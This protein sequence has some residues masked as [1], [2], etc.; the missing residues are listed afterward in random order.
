MRSIKEIHCVPTVFFPVTMEFAAINLV[1]V[2]EVPHL[3]SDLLI[4]RIVLRTTEVQSNAVMGPSYQMQEIVRAHWIPGAF[5]HLEIAIGSATWTA[6]QT[7]KEG[8]EPPMWQRHR[9]TGRI[10]DMTRDETALAHQSRHPNV[11][12][13]GQMRIV[14]EIS[15][16]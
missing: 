12:S 2:V 9:N 7:F 1:E 5:F 6:T 14:S 16:S 13:F 3:P 10:V 8:W 4:F 11:C 15:M